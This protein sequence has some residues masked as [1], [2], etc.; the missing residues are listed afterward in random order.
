MISNNNTRLPERPFGGTGVTVSEVGLGTWPLGGVDAGLGSYGPVD[1]E[2]AINTI[3]CYLDG[4]GRLIDSARAYGPAEA[5]IGR[6]LREG[7]YPRESI[8]I[9]SKS[10]NTESREQFKE[11]RNDLHRTLEDLNTEYV[12]LYQ[13]HRPPEDPALRDEVLSVFELL[14]DEGKIRYIGASIK[15]PLV[16]PDVTALCRDYIA[17]R[18][19]DAI[20][21]IYSIFRQRNSTVFELAKDNGVAVIARTVLES[22]FLTGKYLPGESFK[23]G[24]RA[25]WSQEK[26][27]R[28][29]AAAAELKKLCQS[30]GYETVAQLAQRFALADPRVSSIIPGAR[31]PS[32]CR[33][34]LD[35]AYVSELPSAILSELRSWDLEGVANP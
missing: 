12:D 28:L 1:S 20:Q 29:V 14:R 17:T 15:G 30:A 27:D 25:R 2:M 8:F 3:R 7:S 34:N 5:H 23:A 11:I 33:S 24:H 21:V 31:N 10:Q 13:L 16:T 9:A 19:V 18:R 32:Q 4:G 35:V 6:A 22:G 26:I